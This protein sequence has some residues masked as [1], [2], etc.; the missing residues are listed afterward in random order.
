MNNDISVDDAPIYPIAN[1]NIYHYQASADYN[2]SRFM[3]GQP[4]PVATGLNGNWAEENSGLALG[5]GTLMVLPQGGTF[6]IV[7]AQ[8]NSQAMEAMIYFRQEMMAM[9]AKLSG[10]AG[11]GFNT[12][13]EAMI[14][15][16]SENGRLQ[17][18][19]DNIE[20]AYNAAFEAVGEFMGKQ[21][22]EF[23]IETDLSALTADPQLVQT[24]VAAWQGG[25]LGAPDVRSYMRKVGI[26][27]RDDDEVEADIVDTIM[28]LDSAV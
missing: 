26:L 13:T 20:A 5:S 23:K 10:E 12:A 18:G 28:P 14:A 8:P 7:Q 27:E 16:A 6:E 22:P 19:M 21:A 2:N 15:S 3:I 1:L 4:Q 17:T 25:L 11:A 24:L 9:G